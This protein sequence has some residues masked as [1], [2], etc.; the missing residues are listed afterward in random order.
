MVSGKRRRGN[1]QKV[2]VVPLSLFLVRFEFFSMEEVRSDDSNKSKVGLVRF[3]SMVVT[4]GS[5]TSLSLIPPWSERERVEGG[6]ERAQFM[7]AAAS[8]G[9]NIYLS[10]ILMTRCPRMREFVSP[11]K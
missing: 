11:R 8:D 6:G 2:V 9:A 10:S 3:V 7:F 1:F 4:L 5:A